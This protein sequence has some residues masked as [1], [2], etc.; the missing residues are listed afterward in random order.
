MRTLAQRIEARREVKQGANDSDCTL[1]EAL[2]ELCT[3]MDDAAQTIA[4]A[5]AMAQDETRRSLDT[6]RDEVT[7]QLADALKVR[8]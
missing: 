3:T 2:V 8:R 5:V 7:A 4:A 1:I 6:L